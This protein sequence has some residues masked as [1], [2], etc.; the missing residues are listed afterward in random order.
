MTE[1]MIN[2]V[3]NK[4]DFKR[5]SISVKSEKK[6]ID[7]FDLQQLISVRDVAMK[8][9]EIDHAGYVKTISSSNMAA[10]LELSALFYSICELKRSNKILDLGSGFSSFVSRFYS[11]ENKDVSCYSVD[12]DKTWLMRTVDYLNEKQVDSS[13]CFVLD[14]F[15]SSDESEFDTILLDLNYVEVRRNFIGLTIE[16]CKKGGLILFDDV[17][18]ADYRYDVL[19]QAGSLITL[20]DIRSL[21]LDQFGRYAFLGV[22]K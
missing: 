10:S 22:K 12:D 19:K 14:Q 6:L 15:I 17:H 8:S 18:K 3:I 16:R 13:N 4:L 2:R 21:T 11:Q 7:L 20:Y 1:V 9:L 5:L